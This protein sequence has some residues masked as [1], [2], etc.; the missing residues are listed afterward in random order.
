MTNALHTFE[1]SGLGQAPFK[2]IIPAKNY[3]RTCPVFFCEHCGRQLKN[4]H[5]VADK[6]GRVSVVGSSCILKS[7]DAGLAAGFKRL[8][9]EQ[10]QAAKEQQRQAM[11]ASVEAAQR[12]ALDGH[13]LAELQ[14]SLQEQAEQARRKLRLELDGT[15]L[16]DALQQGMDKFNSFCASMLWQAQDAKPYTAAQRAAVLDV[17]TKFAANGARKNSPAYREKMQL[18]SDALASAEHTISKFADVLAALEADFN[19][20][21]HKVA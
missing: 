16:A 12:Q 17:M 11:L 10:R 13:T 8:Q 5:F 4:R 19:A 3:L 2:A 15:L 14:S 9:R 18:A 21:R 6:N 7:G 1:I 20:A